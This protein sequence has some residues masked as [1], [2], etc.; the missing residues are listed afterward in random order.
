M[1]R[2]FDAVLQG[3]DEGLRRH[4]GLHSACSIPQLPGFDSDNHDID[5]AR[6]CRVVGCVCMND[7]LARVRFNAKALCAYSL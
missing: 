1:G 5:R 3:N 2:R 6:F 4:H 7:L